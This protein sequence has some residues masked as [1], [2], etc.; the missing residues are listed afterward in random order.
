M[1][2]YLDH[3]P[4]RPLNSALGRSNNGHAVTVCNTPTEI[5]DHLATQPE[6]L[7]VT[8]DD[9]LSI[10]RNPETDLVK[11]PRPDERH[12]TSLSP[13]LVFLLTVLAMVLLFLIWK[14]ASS[15]KSVIQHGYAYLRMLPRLRSYTRI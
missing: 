14:R 11:E 4:A 1:G 5:S 15:L 9:Y 13:A 3:R 2:P 6:I 8:L 10:M 7:L 12:D